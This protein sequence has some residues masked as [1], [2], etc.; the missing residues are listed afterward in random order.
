MFAASCPRSFAPWG[1]GDDFFR[2]VGAGSFAGCGRFTCTFTSRPHLAS[3]RSV[4]SSPDTVSVEQAE[5]MK[6]PTS[7]AISR[8]ALLALAPLLATTPL[9][10]RSAL[11]GE[12]GVFPPKVSVISTPETC[13]GR[14]KEQDFVCIKYVGK[15]IDTGKVFD[16]RYAQRPLI[17][18][19]GS[20]YIPGV[21]AALENSCVG[22]RLKLTWVQSPPLGAEFE[23]LLP[24]GTPI[25]LDIEL[26]NI[27]YSLFGEKM[28]DATSS[29]RFAQEKLTLTS[30]PDFERGFA[31]AREPVIVKDNPFSI[32]AGEK[33]LISNPQS[34]LGPIFGELKLPELGKWQA[35]PAGSAGVGGDTGGFSMP[36]LPF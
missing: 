22:N 30:A 33:N 16:D 1:A 31:A 2:C 21:D 18:E 20:F 7:T 27:K 25:E 32:A 26:V 5:P 19:L 35:T 23:E 8:R 9:P 34:V 6:L 28:R 14:C 13:Q 15:R 36:K 17:Y 3:S 4:P 29:Y 12:P 11:A 24:A 10:T